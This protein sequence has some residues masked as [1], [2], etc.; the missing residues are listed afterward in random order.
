MEVRISITIDLKFTNG[1]DGE[2][3]A[4]V[5]IIPSVV[6]CVHSD[7]EIYGYPEKYCYEKNNILFSFEMRKVKSSFKLNAHI[8]CRSQN[9]IQANRSAIVGVLLLIVKVAHS[10]AHIVIYRWNPLSPGWVVGI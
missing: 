8:L 1:R 9:Q 3:L 7:A 4:S 5:I 2:A 6:L 10:T